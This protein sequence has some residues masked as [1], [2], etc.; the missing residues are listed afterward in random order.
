MSRQS[1]VDSYEGEQNRDR[2]RLDFFGDLILFQIN[3]KADL[4][5]T[6]Y[7]PL[8]KSF[9]LCAIVF[10]DFRLVKGQKVPARFNGEF[11]PLIKGSFSR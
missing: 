11:R 10:R 5:S 1:S 7:H 4:F 8:M 6:L 3:W 2:P 9:W